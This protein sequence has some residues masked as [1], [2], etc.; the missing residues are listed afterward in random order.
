MCSKKIGLQLE[1]RIRAP[2]ATA[3]FAGPDLQRRKVKAELVHDIPKRP[4]IFSITDITP[5]AERNVVVLIA[6]R[7]DK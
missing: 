5:K 3:I 2:S 4:D 1:W 6:K 7:S